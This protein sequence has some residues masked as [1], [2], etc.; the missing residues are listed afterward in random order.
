MLKEA[1]YYARMAHYYGRFIKA[2]PIAD[3]EAAIR[4]TLLRREENF[5]NLSGPFSLLIVSTVCC[6]KDPSV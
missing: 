4:E 3:P 6:R 2:A 5:L 1:L